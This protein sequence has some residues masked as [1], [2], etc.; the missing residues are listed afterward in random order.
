MLLCY[1]DD[2]RKWNGM[3]IIKKQF[4]DLRTSTGV[5][6]STE[7]TNKNENF[8]DFDFGQKNDTAA[9][10]SNPTLIL[11]LVFIIFYYYHCYWL[12]FHMSSSKQ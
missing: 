8:V 3:E 7:I 6:I 12:G 1:D 4:C 5:C 2:N 9:K 11:V 10:S